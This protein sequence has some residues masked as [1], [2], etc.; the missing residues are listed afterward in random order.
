MFYHYRLENFHVHLLNKN[1]A[2]TFCTLYVLINTFMT[3][4]MAQWV[5]ALVSQAE[6]WMYEF[7]P[8]HT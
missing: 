1:T 2:K 5:R 8:R 3:A 6:G 7:P 4:A